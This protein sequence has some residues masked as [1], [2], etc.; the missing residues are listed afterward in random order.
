[1]GFYLT[2][3]L[4]LK[5]PDASK[6]LFLGCIF[7]AKVSNKLRRKL[8]EKALRGIMVGYPLDPPGYHIYNL[9][10]RRITTSVHVVLPEGVSGFSPSVTIDS[11]ITCGSHT[12]GD[13]GLAT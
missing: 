2:L 8:G 5:E 4:T 3:L 6:F 13:R 10:A 9:A 7:F 1:V 11:W 12:D